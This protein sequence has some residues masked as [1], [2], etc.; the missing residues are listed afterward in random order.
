MNKSAL[1]AY[2][3]PRPSL[4]RSMVV[5]LHWLWARTVGAFQGGR[6]RY[7]DRFG[8]TYYLWPD[9]RLIDTLERG[10]RIDDEGMLHAIQGIMNCYNQHS[11][12]ERVVSVDVGGFLGVVTL[13]IA[14]KMR[15]YDRAYVFEALP[16]NATRIVENMK[17]NKLSNVEVINS[18]MS[19]TVRRDKLKLSHSRSGNYLDPKSSAVD[20]VMEPTGHSIEI[21]VTSLAAFAETHALEKIDI[22]KIDAEFQDLAILKGAGGLLTEGRIHYLFVEEPP[23]DEAFSEAIFAM[24]L[25][26]NYTTYHIVRRHPEVVV[27]MDRYP[28]HRARPPLN[29][30]AVS[31]KAPFAPEKLGLHIL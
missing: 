17:L 11:T 13:A 21:D 6:Y 27:D 30:L 19:D 18:A 25:Q 7:S 4:M 9:T 8:L 15:S 29:I 28:Y 14:S 5:H 31:P 1:P 16:G 12:R 20:K 10:V 22:M 3:V 23:Q 26:N 2:Q 24:L